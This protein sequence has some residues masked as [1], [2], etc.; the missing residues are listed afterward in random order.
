MPTK[1]AHQA[2]PLRAVVEPGP[3]PVVVMPPPVPEPLRLRGLA[4]ARHPSEDGQPMA[5]NTRQ[6]RTM[7]DLEYPVRFRYKPREDVFVGIDLLVYY[8]E[9]AKPKSVAPDIL[10]SFDVPS[11]PR[12][13]YRIEEE[14]KPPD[15][16]LEVASPTTFEHDVG[17]KKDLYE[18]IGVGEYWVYDPQGD[19]HDPRLRGWVLGPAG[20]QELADLGRPGVPVALW[21]EALGLELHFDGEDLRAW[22]PAVPGYLRRIEDSERRG[23]IAEQRAD[24]ESKR[25]DYESK[26]A[27]DE[28]KRAD[29]ERRRADDERRRA[30][31]EARARRAAEQRADKERRHAEKEA[32]ARREMEARNAVLEEQ[33]RRLRNQS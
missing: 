28:S 4:D 13:I 11:Y 25:A 22:D 12:E 31:T 32:R 1:K 15:W 3:S 14:G 23:D 6:G 16:V 30:E 9:G 2:L 20:Y 26:R 8:R 29:D 24:Y 33:L 27:D 7:V 21:S 10:V 19:M 18:E 5:T 17:D